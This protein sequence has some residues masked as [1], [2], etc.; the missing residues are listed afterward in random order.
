MTG[1]KRWFQS[2]SRQKAFATAGRLDKMIGWSNVGPDPALLGVGQS[3]MMRANSLIGII[4]FCLATFGPALPRASI[5]EQERAVLSAVQ[6]LKGRSA[7]RP[8]GET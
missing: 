6:F 1:A 7:G 4:S 2:E 8:A 3:M 5:A